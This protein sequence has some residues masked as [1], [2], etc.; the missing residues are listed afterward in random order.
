MKNKLPPSIQVPAS[1]PDISDVV[2]KLLRAAGVGETLP[3]PKEEII[4][5]ARLV[6]SGE[7]DLAAYE[8]TL[9]EKARGF[10]RK[11]MGKVLGF[12][13]RRTEMFYVDPEIRGPRRKFITFHEVTHKI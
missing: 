5:S 9:T 12:V 3:T 13:D 11:A 1:A 4:R 8:E 2:Q 6:E 7:L 10:F